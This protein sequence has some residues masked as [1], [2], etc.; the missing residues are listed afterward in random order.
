[1]R[2]THIFIWALGYVGAISA[3]GHLFRPAFFMDKNLTGQK[4]AAVT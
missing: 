2:G 4:Q 3:T 1:M